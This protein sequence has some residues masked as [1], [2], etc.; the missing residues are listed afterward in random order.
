MTQAVVVVGL[1]VVVVVAGGGRGKKI[2]AAV[3]GV[4]GTDCGWVWG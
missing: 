3:L 4:V 1:V 2:Q